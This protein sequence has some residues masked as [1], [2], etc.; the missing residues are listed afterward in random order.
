MTG[1]S[2]NSGGQVVLTGSGTVIPEGGTAV[3]SG[4]LNASGQ[5]GGPVNVLGDKVSVIGSNINASGI[6]GGGTVLIGGDYQGKGT[7][8]NATRTFVSSDSIINADAI[9]SSNGGRIIAWADQSNR[10]LGTITARGGSLSGN[11]GFA[12]V[13]GKENFDFRGNVNTT[14]VNGNAGMV[15][16]DPTNITVINGAGSFTDLS[17]VDNFAAPDVGD[18]TIDAALINN[19]STNVTLQATKDITFSTPVNM[20][21]AGVGLTA[22]AN[23]NINVNSSIITNNGNLTL[24]LDANN[25]NGGALTV[26]GARIS[27]GAGAITL[28]GRGFDGT[29]GNNGG[30]GITLSNSQLI[31]TTGAIT[32]T[33]TG[34]AGGRGTRGTNGLNGGSGGAGIVV[35]N[36]SITSTSGLIALTG[37]GGIGGAGGGGQSV[38]SYRQNVRAGD[39]GLRFSSENRITLQRDETGNSVFQLAPFVNLGTVWNVSDNPNKLQRQPFLVGAGLGLL[40]SPLPKLNLR[41]DYGLPLVN[42]VDR[43]EK[44]QDSGF[45][46][47]VNYQL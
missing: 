18:N 22:L 37:T 42:L 23:R 11:G 43:G 34:G 47:S 19:A 15:L 46:F 5:I 17:Q 33:G 30:D 39:N 9:N 21:N 12:E 6:N 32:L 45:Y 13:S 36:S 1:V 7:I 26:N 16:L 10:F 24:T 29:V 14:A 8:P 27:T 20:T 35:T 2:V 38:R 25:T 31:T 4:T 40:Y 41:L 3:T 44:V 28:A